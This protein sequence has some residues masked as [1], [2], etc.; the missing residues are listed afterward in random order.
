[1]QVTQA[2]STIIKI[3]RNAV[4]AE[5]MDWLMQDIMIVIADI[6]TIIDRESASTPRNPAMEVG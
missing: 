6:N 1:M 4:C 2:T 3:G 5:M